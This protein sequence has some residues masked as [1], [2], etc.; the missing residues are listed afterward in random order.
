M[1]MYSTT[2]EIYAN[3]INYSMESV[4]NIMATSISTPEEWESG[5]QFFCFWLHL[6]FA[7]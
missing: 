2:L 4:F 7:L 5:K 3:Y 6:M 1:Q